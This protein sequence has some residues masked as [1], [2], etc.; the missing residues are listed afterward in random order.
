MGSQTLT[1]KLPFHTVYLHSMV[2]D[3]YGSKMSKSK[4][5]VID[6][7]DVIEG[8]TLEHLVSVLEKS[9]LPKKEIVKNVAAN[10]KLY[11]KG[12]ERCGADA[13]RFGLL[14][15]NRLQGRDVNLD[16]NRVLGYRKFCNKLWNLHRLGNHFG[17]DDPSFV[18]PASIDE[19]LALDLSVAD[20]WILSRLHVL[21]GA[22]NAAFEAYDFANACSKVYDFL[23]KEFAQIY[24]E[25]AKPIV[26]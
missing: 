25:I 11:P 12:I 20:R 15:E 13:L 18:A 10:R 22:V 23:L 2:R 17:M 14:M 24:A 7:M 16:I 19:L 5:N 4:G 6:P 26:K 1:G 3:K 8:A 9:L 21:C